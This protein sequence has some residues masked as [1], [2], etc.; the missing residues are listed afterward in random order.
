MLAH[1]VLHKIS[2]DTYKWDI[3]PR[4][5]L[6]YRV[7][8]TLPLIWVKVEVIENIKGYISTRKTPLYGEGIKK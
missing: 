6:T 2:I 7:Y 3:F 4:F 1:T 5:M 8:I